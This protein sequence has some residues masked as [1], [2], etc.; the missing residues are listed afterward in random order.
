MRQLAFDV[1]TGTDK[2]LRVVVVLFNPGRH[3]ENIRVEN[4]VFRREAHL[5]GENLV[6][7]AANL[8]FTRAGI[9]GPVHQRPS[10]LPPRH[11]DAAA[12]RDG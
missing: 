10:P 8:D 2:V 7:T 11:S 5:F 6:R 1:F 4:D 3:R 9:R 12:S